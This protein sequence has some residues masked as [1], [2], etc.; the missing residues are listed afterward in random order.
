MPSEGAYLVTCGQVPHLDRLIT[1]STDQSVF[2]CAY[3]Y[4][5]NKVCMP[6]EG[7]TAQIR[8]RRVQNLTY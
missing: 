4:T 7:N 6:S 8:D 5:V 2:V 1:A 3:C